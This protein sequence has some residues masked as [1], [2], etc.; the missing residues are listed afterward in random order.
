MKPG[1]EMDA[2]VAEKVMGWKYYVNRFR[3]GDGVQEY[4]VWKNN[5]GLNASRFPPKFSTEIGP[6]FEVVNYSNAMTFE[7][8]ANVHKNLWC[9]KF[10][11]MDSHVSG[12]SAPHAICLAA[13][14]IMEKVCDK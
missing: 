11:G 9:C 6:A 10:S 7:L 5:E 2:E 8:Y 4:R 12:V 1:P 14:Q 13:L 3:T